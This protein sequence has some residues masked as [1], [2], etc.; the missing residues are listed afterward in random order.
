VAIELVEDLDHYDLM[1]RLIPEWEAVRCHPQRNVL[2]TFTVDRHLCEAAANASR[3]VDRVVRPDLLVVGALFHD[4]GKGYTGDHT[5]V[6]MR[7][8]AEMAGRMGYPDEEVAVLVDLCRHHL[9]LPDFATRRDLSDP[10]TVSAVAA[11][12]DTV[13]FLNLLAALTEADSMATGPSAWGSWKAGLLNELVTR[14]AFVL[15]G[16]APADAAVT[17]FP[18]PDVLDLMTQGERRLSGNGSTFLVVAPDRPALFS[19]MAGVLAVSGLDVLDASAHSAD[20]MAA[21][22]FTLQ[23]PAHGVVDWDKVTAM[24]DRALDGR[25][26]LTA[27]VHQRAQNYS[28][29]RRRLSATPPGY[30]VV[31][32]NDI[33]DLATVVEVHAPDAVGL[34]FWI[35]QAL[36]ELR[37]DIQSAK[38]QTFG[39]QAVDSFYLCDAAGAKLA[40]EELLRELD[41]A[42]RQAVG[43]EAV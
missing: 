24:A 19:Q 31:V 1:T 36:A 20:G 40:D 33:S 42:I 5:E 34:L 37:L 30:A 3:L 26:A 38:V 43:E 28:R 2:H 25:V 23:P 10:G 29:F 13:E 21:C 9:L 32:D 22:Q 14:T 11:A 12:V 18:T 27:R 39:P 7:L 35:T 17:E 8:I 4:I 6:G 41:L 16:G 15:Q